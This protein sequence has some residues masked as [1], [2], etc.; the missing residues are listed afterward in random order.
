MSATSAL[1][2]TGA[3]PSRASPASARA[4]ESSALKVASSRSV[5]A[6]IFSSA[7]VRA[8]DDRDR[9]ASSAHARM[10][11]SGVLRS[12]ATLLDTSRIPAI[13]RS[14]WASMSLRLPESRSSSSPVPAT[15]ILRLRSPFMMERAAAL[16]FSTRLRKSRLI[17]TPPAR[18]SASARPRPH[19]VEVRMIRSKRRRSS[20]SRPTTSL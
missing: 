10:R 5:S 7:A 11:V 4:M 14:I 1:T 13:S 12:W 8:A 9:S 19:T 15:G 20:T 16:I 6:M 17:R 2:S 3:T 18:P